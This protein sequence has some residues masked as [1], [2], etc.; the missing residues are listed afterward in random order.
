MFPNYGVCVCVAQPSA[1]PFPPPPFSR[2]ADG[3]RPGDDGGGVGAGGGV[4]RDPGAAPP[5]QRL[6]GP[7]PRRPRPPPRSR[8][9]RER[10]HGCT[11]I[12]R[13]LFIDSTGPLC[14]LSSS[15]TRAIMISPLFSHIPSGPPHIQ[16]RIP[17]TRSA[18]RTPYQTTPPPSPPPPTHPRVGR[19]AMELF[20]IIAGSIAFVG[21]GVVPVLFFPRHPRT[22][23]PTLFFG[24]WGVVRYPKDVFAPGILSFPKV[25]PLTGMPERLH[26]FLAGFADHTRAPWAHAD[27]AA[28][29][30]PGRPPG[31]PEGR[32]QRLRRRAPRGRPVPWRVG[33]GIV[34]VRPT[35]EPRPPSP[36]SPLTRGDGFHD[37]PNVLYSQK[38]PGC[39]PSL[40]LNR[41]T[42][43]S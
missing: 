2:Q 25:S 24:G 13:C 39:L 41:P 32:R 1:P 4:P 26:A 35:P 43:G 3:E 19:L 20:G 21:Q 7:R 9:R 40:S 37:S 14:L 22:L 36:E 5:P 33:W 6:R 17:T 31:G 12:L 16:G 38:K 30:R 27:A 28:Q 10:P 29:Q 11:P 23:F 8:R 34:L 42:L 15:L 18:L